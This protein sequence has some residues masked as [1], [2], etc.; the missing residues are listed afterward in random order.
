MREDEWISVQNVTKIFKKKKFGVIF[1]REVKALDSV[2]F[3]VRKGEV[4][5]LLGPNGS[6]KTTLLRILLGLIKPTKG[7]TFVAGYMSQKEPIEV[8][9]RAAFLPQEAGVMENLTAR[10][11]IL[12]YGGMHGLDPKL[13]EQRTE[14]LIRV[15][16][17]KGRENEL[18]K[19]FSGGMKR[20][21]LIARTLVVNPEVVF[22]DEP[23]TGIDILGARVIRHLVKQ[24]SEEQERTFI[25][26]SHDISEMELLCDRVGIL[27]NGK[28][29]AIGTP[30]QLAD[31]FDQANLEDVYVGLV[32][33]EGVE[34]HVTV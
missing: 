28:L 4:F 11:N 16:G 13:L 18:T 33:G 25:I 21:V 8:R 6:G 19:D 23:T 24:L 31:L 12:Y 5:G 17:L 2:S 3:A 26:T 7:Q 15:I 29:V 10:E 27:V 14:E 22:L 1:D 34:Q 9:K 20:K 32:T 30:D